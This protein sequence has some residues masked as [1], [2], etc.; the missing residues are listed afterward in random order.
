MVRPTPSPFFVVRRIQRRYRGDRACAVENADNRL[1]TSC[2]RIDIVPTFEHRRDAPTT[3]LVRQRC[4]PLGELGKAALGDAH[5][6]ER[7][8]QMRIEPGRNQHEL[9]LVRSYRRRN[10]VVKY[11]QIGIIPDAGTERKIDR[12]SLTGIAA[13]L[14]RAPAARIKRVLVD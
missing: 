11:P 2:Q 10:H 13:A 5:L 6:A 9:R 8:V 14:L 7:I 1:H 4:C 3:E 12:V